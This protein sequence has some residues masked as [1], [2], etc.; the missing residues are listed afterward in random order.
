MPLVQAQAEQREQFSLMMAAEK[1]G[2]QA[3][4]DAF[5]WLAARK[6]ADPSNFQIDHQRIMATAHPYAALVK[7][8]QQSQILGEI[9]NDPVSYKERLRAELLAELQSSDG[10]TPAG[11]GQR[12]ATPAVMPSNFADARTA[13]PRN[14]GWTGPPSLKDIF[15]KG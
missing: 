13:A 5:Q 11:P 9:G 1:Y 15:A 4:N 2:E 3:V 10:F 7:A 12:P 14:V 6:A 8:H